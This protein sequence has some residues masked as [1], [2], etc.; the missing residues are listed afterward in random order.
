MLAKLQLALLTVLL[1]S[2]VSGCASPRATQA[3]I[4]ITLIA[5][6]EHIDLQLPAGSTVQQALDTAG[7]S[8]NA[9]DRTEPPIYTV[10]RQ[11]ASVHLI[12]VLEE[13]EIEEVLIPFESQTLRNES[14]P[15]E[16]EL[17]IQKG[18]NG[19]KEVTYRRVYENGVEITEKPIAVKEVVVNDPI[20]EIRM[21]GVQ[22]PL[23]PIAIP[24]KLIYL[25]DGSV[26][27]IENTTGNRQAI[28]TTG[29][30][31][32][33]V[34]S[35]SSDGSWLLFTRHEEGEQQINSL[36]VARIGEEA[37]ESPEGEA[38]IGELI[39]LDVYNVVHFADWAPGSNTKIIF[40]TVEPRST[41]PGWQANNDLHSL[42]FSTSGWT[43]KWATLIEANS[44][45]VYG[46]WGTVFAWGP[47]RQ[48]LAFARPDSVGTINYEDGSMTTFL[49]I[50]PLLTRGD[51]AWVPGVTWGP[52]GS[53]L[54]TVNHA[55]P[56]GAVSP[57]ES[58][59]FDLTA[60]PLEAGPSLPLVSQA[61]MFAYPLA[62]PVQ[63][64]ASGDIDYRI[65]Y[66]QAIF[67]TQSETSRYS[68]VVMDR[69]GSN[70]QNLFP[71]E[72]SPGLEPQ[73]HWGAWSP[74]VMPESG[75]FAIALLYQGNL[76]LVDTVNGERLQ[77]TGDGLTTRIIWR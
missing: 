74:A 55:S 11:G 39:A 29:D 76:W 63:V 70:R 69:D 17:L 43:T 65:A 10:L 6:G 13:F 25:R 8:Q 12:R 4:E 75:N 35:L 9:L 28:L 77:I 22:T 68:L 50:T 45:G 58:Q 3:L 23:A 54:Y 16:Q 19:L 36:W 67:P 62:S 71:G 30:L 34:F 44:G 60:I 46:W 31:D 27:V 66:L 32:S 18:Q 2:I 49:E 21:V 53:I 38:E 47:D 51:W 24:G 52:N 37:D 73:Q 59:L 56:P 33:R 15:V 26:W 20:P 72:E 57:E 7:L 42:T 41:A 40:S 61:G 5:D 14:L 48:R 64:Q 1:G